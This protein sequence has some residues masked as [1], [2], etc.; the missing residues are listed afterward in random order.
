MS[1]QLCEECLKLI[2]IRPDLL[3]VA[4]SGG[5][6]S[7]RA[8]WVRTKLDKSLLVALEQGL[9]DQSAGASFLGQLPQLCLG[10]RL[11]VEDPAQSFLQG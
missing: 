10:H 6:V 3:R 7:E 5:N 11:L 1:L 2:E 9:E 4:Q 8:S